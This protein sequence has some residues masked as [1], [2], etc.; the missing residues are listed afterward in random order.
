MVA[1]INGLKIAIISLNCHVYETAEVLRPLVAKAREK[2]AG[3]IIT[4]I[5]WGSRSKELPSD[6]QKVQARMAADLGSDYIVG[7]GNRVIQPLEIITALD[8]RQV[9][10]AYALGNFQS[11][12]RKIDS[13]RESIAIM[14]RLKMDRAG[15]VTVESNKYV[16]FYIYP[17]LDGGKWVTA[18]LSE[19]Y[20][21]GVRLKDRDD[22]EDNIADE[23]GD[24]IEQE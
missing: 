12:Q 2:G 3:Y 18:P 17:S 24:L 4:Y 14:L 6:L 11:S 5:C 8:G 19:S 10:S 13:N 22:I 20:N 15:R 9:P 21:T 1:E 7:S 16:P 23:V